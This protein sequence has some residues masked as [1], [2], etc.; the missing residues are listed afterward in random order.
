MYKDFYNTKKLY[1]N[2][3]NQYY[4]DYKKLVLKHYEN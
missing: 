3:K 4:K 1:V 2:I